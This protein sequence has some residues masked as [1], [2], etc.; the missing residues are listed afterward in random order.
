MSIPVGYLRHLVATLTV[1][2]VL[3]DR[4]K[5]PQTC[6]RYRPRFRLR[7]HGMNSL[8]PF[9]SIGHAVDHD[10][11]LTPAL[12]FGP[13]SPRARGERKEEKNPLRAV[14]APGH[15]GTRPY[16]ME[17]PSARDC[18][19]DAFRAAPRHRRSR[20][21]YSTDWKLRRGLREARGAHRVDD[22]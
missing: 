7:E 12:D 13:R 8:S 6:D 20:E 15:T 4:S 18:P 3:A 17:M 22:L 2:V 19:M 5:L 14:R 21:V 11:D 9:I 16:G 10:L 1:A